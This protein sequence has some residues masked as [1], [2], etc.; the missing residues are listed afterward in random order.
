MRNED[1]QI[2]DPFV[3]PVPG[4]GRY[5]LFGSTDANIWGKGTGFDVYIG[6]D[7]LEWEGPYP[8]FRPEADFYSE[9]NF[10]APEVY[11][12]R[13][14]Y[15]MFATFRRRSN[16]LLGTG[17]L[18]S[19]DLKG[20]F[21]PYSDGP[22]TPENW[23]CLDGT[24]YVDNEGLPWMVFCHEWTQVK[25]G[26]ICAMRLTEDL[27]AAAGEPVLLFRA[28]QAGWTTRLDSKST[29]AGDVFVTDGAYVHRAGNGQLLLL[30]AS[31]VHNRYAIGVA[32]SESGLITGPW[33]HEE[34][35]LYQQDGGHG[36]LF[37][38]FDGQLML[39][40]HTPNKTP[41]ERPVFLPVTE[42]QGRLRMV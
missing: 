14:R 11:E 21:R 8:V 6:S 40:I 38:T 4:E 24:L 27:K 7:L 42:E 25:D 36:M 35:A 2:R 41:N 16:Q 1:L 33:V 23:P 15:Y 28:S 5:Y 3:V 18:A 30:W 12:Y 37:R 9:E 26:E 32:R 29:E 17:V 34:Q 20:P 10:W 19:D 22:V 31:F 39:T 13:G